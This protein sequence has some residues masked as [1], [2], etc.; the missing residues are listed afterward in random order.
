M[1]LGVRDFLEATTPTRTPMIRQIAA[2]SAIQARTE[3]AQIVYNAILTSTFH[4]GQDR[5]LH[6]QIG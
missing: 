1:F 6:R 3:R 2:K 5:N 4:A